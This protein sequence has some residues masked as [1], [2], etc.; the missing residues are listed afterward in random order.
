MNDTQFQQLADNLLYHI[1]QQLDLY[2]GDADIDCEIS[3]GVM[4]L[5][6]SNGRQIVINRQQ[7]LQ[8]IWLATP[9]NGYHFDYIDGNWICTRSGRSFSELL[10]E[11][12]SKQAGDE[13]II[14]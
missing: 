8:Q 2:Q 4:T 1:E 3:G 10:S 13:I 9:D 6:F 12:C 11:A 7:P 14:P 5:S